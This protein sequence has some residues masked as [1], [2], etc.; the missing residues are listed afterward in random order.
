M[1]LY[2]CNILH[3]HNN[4]NIKSKITLTVITN[5]EDVFYMILDERYNEL[6]FQ[7]NPK[8]ELNDPQNVKNVSV[9]LKMKFDELKSS[10]FRYNYN[11]GNG[12]EGTKN[13]YLEDFLTFLKNENREI[14]INNLLNEN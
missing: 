10:D 6:D 2:C 5:D 14:I 7:Y 13:I 9:Y 11:Y 8:F 1:R 12:Y 3:N 4:N